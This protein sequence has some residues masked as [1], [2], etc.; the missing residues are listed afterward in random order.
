VSTA[1]PAAAVLH[2]DGPRSQANAGRVLARPPPEP[3]LRR[4]RTSTFNADKAGAANNCTKASAAVKYDQFF[5][6]DPSNATQMADAAL[7]QVAAGT[8]LK[9]GWLVTDCTATLP[10]ICQ[11]PSTIFPC[12]PPPSS[13]P[14][15]PQPPSPPSPP[16]S[17]KCEQARTAPSSSPLPCHLVSAAQPLPARCT[18]DEGCACCFPSAGTPKTNTTFFCEPNSGNCFLLRTATADMLGFY[19][20]ADL[21]ASYVSGNLVTYSSRGKQLLV[22]GAAGVCA[23]CCRSCAGKWRCLSAAR[24]ISCTSG[25]CACSVLTMTALLGSLLPAQVE[26]YFGALL[27]AQYWHGAS[28]ASIDTEYTLTDGLA[29]SQVGGHGRHW[30][31]R[32]GDAVHTGWLGFDCSALPTRDP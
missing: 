30:G 24:A 20:A 5:G 19:Q 17:T 26:K 3:L 9:Y 10:F 6:L 7:Y 21:C 31:G 1:Q 2:N 22:R 23:P 18:A 27:P 13:P 28:R 25:H 8:D 11:V 14:P 32:C 12:Y 4:R 15:P 16:M 29:I